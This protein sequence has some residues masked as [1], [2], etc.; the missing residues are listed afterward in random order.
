V[1]FTQRTATKRPD[2][3]KIASTAYL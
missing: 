2:R 3:Q 1:K